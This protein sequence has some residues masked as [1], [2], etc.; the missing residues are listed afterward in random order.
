MG[1]GS[2]CSRR[3]RVKFKVCS[4]YSKQ[5]KRLTTLNQTHSLLLSGFPITKMDPSLLNHSLGSAPAQSQNGAEDLR[6]LSVNELLFAVLNEEQKIAFLLEKIT[7]NCNNSNANAPTETLHVP[8]MDQ[9][10]GHR[11]SNIN[12]AQQDAFVEQ[13][14]AGNINLDQFSQLLLEHQMVVAAEKSLERNMA[15]AAGKDKN[16]GPPPTPNTAQKNSTTSPTNQTPCWPGDNHLISSTG[17]VTGTGTTSSR[18][19]R[20]GSEVLEVPR[21]PVAQGGSNLVSTA[22]R[23]AEGPRLR[24]GP[25][26]VSNSRNMKVPQVPQRGGGG[27]GIIKNNNNGMMMITPAQLQN[28]MMNQKNSLQTAGTRSTRTNDNAAAAPMAYQQQIQIQQFL[29]AQHQQ[30]KQIPVPPQVLRQQKNHPPAHQ[31][32]RQNTQSSPQMQQQNYQPHPLMQQQQ[33]Q[34]QQKNLLRAAHLQPGSGAQHYISPPPSNCLKRP[35]DQETV[36]ALVNL[37]GGMAKKAKNVKKPPAF[38]RKNQ[39]CGLPAL[40]H[41][42]HHD[43]ARNQA[44]PPISSPVCVAPIVPKETPPELLQPANKNKITKITEIPKV[45][46]G[47]RLR[48]LLNPVDI[49]L[50]TEFTYAVLSELATCSFASND[51]RGNRSK[52]SY[53]Y[54]G[55]TCRYCRGYSKV[56]SLMRT[57]RYFPTTIKTMADSKKTLIPMYDHLSNCEDVPIIV[58]KQLKYLHQR[59]CI[60]VRDK[61]LPHGGQRYF[62]RKIWNKIHK[63][64]VFESKEHRSKM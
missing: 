43:P 61:K 14:S 55:F 42:R 24:Q 16:P 32:Q 62:F 15:A 44:N 31:V 51:N 1:L 4:T 64:Q 19:S 30:N 63:K 22:R 40:Q 53:G 47:T 46:E 60:E 8:F 17:T 26:L 27:G 2:T 41:I 21:V 58:K 38:T 7:K 59:H 50:V 54:P 39:T 37:S 25:N 11:S 35:A 23:M 33:V 29:M 45:P 10:Q 36:G 28:L 49:H 20:A 52:V 56:D 12:T 9:S 34:V 18:T 5:D 3:M 13:P 57:G 6:K 48:I